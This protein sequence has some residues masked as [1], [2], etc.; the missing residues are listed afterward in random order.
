MAAVTALPLPVAIGGDQHHPHAHRRASS[1][2]S[3][4]ALLQS[5][6]SKVAES[7]RTPK[8]AAVD[9]DAGSDEDD[10][11]LDWES[12]SEDDDS[13]D[14]DEDDVRGARR[15]FQPMKKV[16]KPEKANVSGRRKEGVNGG[17]DDVGPLP[18]RTDLGRVIELADEDDENDVDAIGSD[19]AA[20]AEESA[21]AEELAVANKHIRSRTTS[22]SNHMGGPSTVEDHE[23]RFHSELARAGQLVDLQETYLR[24]RADRRAEMVAGAMEALATF[25]AAGL[26]LGSRKSSWTKMVVEEVVEV[27]EVVITE[28]TVD[29]LEEIGTDVKKEDGYKVSRGS[30]GFEQFIPTKVPV[31]GGVAMPAIFE[32]I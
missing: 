30:R 25:G 32:D 8:S 28:M 15:F 23:A 7:M 5:V 13:A 16:E 12:G 4:G 6:V 24:N 20:A 3:Y 27:E 29:G 17:G 22:S 14:D 19:A 11:G 21:V 1:F 26:E 10:D 31:F 18:F 2:D 9:A